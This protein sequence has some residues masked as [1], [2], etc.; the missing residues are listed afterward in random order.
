[1]IASAILS[2]MSFRAR[3]ASS[4][5]GITYEI[6]SGSQFVS[7]I[8]AI[9]TLSLFASPTARCS[10]RVST[11]YMMSGRSWRC[12]MP[13]RRLLSFSILRSIVSCSRF[14]S[15]ANSPRSRRLSR[16][17]SV[18]TRWRIV[19]QFVSIPPSQRSTTYGIPQRS[20]ASWRLAAACFLVPTNST[21]PPLAA[22]ERTASVAS[23]SFS[24]VW[25][26]SRMWIPLRSVKMYGRIFGFQRRV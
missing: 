13:P 10:R 22:T 7:T 25:A 14:E 20:A 19:C 26:R 12:L 18:A 8:A 23:V 11:T 1:M 2:V 21:V 16:S 5:D 3:I 17:S 9:G 24:T 4:L 15:I 6:G